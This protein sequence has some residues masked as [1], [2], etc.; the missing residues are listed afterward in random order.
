MKLLALLFILPA[1][2]ACSDDVATVGVESGK[3][4]RVVDGDTVELGSGAKARVLGIDTPEKGQ[5]GYQEAKKN[6]QD[7]VL[8]KRI[9]LVKDGKQTTDR[10][11]RLLR[12]IDLG[13][14]DIGDEQIKAGLAHARYDSYD[15]DSKGKSIYPKHSREDKYHNDDDKSKDLCP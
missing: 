12:Y 15:K 4:V 2:G 7:L 9:V 11:Q 5:C 10:Y 3:V 13:G 6:M 14:K 1:L 8:N